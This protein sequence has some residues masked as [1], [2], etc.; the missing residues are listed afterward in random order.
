M[1]TETRTDVWEADDDACGGGGTWTEDVRGAPRSSTVSSDICRGLDVDKQVRASSSPPSP[2]TRGASR[3][4]L[5]VGRHVDGRTARERTDPDP[6]AR[7]PYS[8]GKDLTG[9]PSRQVRDENAENEIYPCHGQTAPLANPAD[10]QSACVVHS[11]YKYAY[12]CILM[13]TCAT[14]DDRV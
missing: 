10:I 12:M 8:P 9:N 4:F 5:A 13:Y 3:G 2:P 1:A 6:D 14:R 7:G 11:P